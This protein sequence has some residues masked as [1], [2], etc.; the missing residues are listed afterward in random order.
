MPEY[1]NWIGGLNEKKQL[2]IIYVSDLLIYATTIVSPA[3][4]E[5][6]L[7]VLN[8]LINN[9]FMASKM[10]KDIYDIVS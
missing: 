1:Q 4:R 6:M 7:L 9:Y 10:S 8:S 2:T 3:K 5:K